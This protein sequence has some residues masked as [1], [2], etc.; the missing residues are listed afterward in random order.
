MENPVK[1]DDLGVP[2]W[3]IGKLQIS[4]P[5]M[6]GATWTG[7]SILKTVHAIRLRRTTPS[8]FIPDSMS[9]IYLEDMTPWPNAA[10]H[11]QML[12]SNRKSNGCVWKCCV[13]L[14]PMVFMIIIPFLNGYFIENINPTFSDKPKS[15]L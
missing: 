4:R 8:E 9:T 5:K 6:F 1:M 12:Q 2:R 13:A 10:E 11:V 3:R 15:F 14:N 7:L